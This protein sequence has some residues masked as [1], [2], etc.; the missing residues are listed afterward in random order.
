[1]N[2]KRNLVL[3]G[4][5]STILAGHGAAR[6]A[7]CV[8]GQ[9]HC[10]E[11]EKPLADMAESGRQN[12]PTFYG[13]QTVVTGTATGTATNGMLGSYVSTAPQFVDNP[14]PVIWPSARG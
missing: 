2:G 5:I 13:V 10:P 7:P 3:A 1:M 11:P 14:Q 6:P 12:A 8:L 9:Y 4:V